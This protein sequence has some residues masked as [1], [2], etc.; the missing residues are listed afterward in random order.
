MY[1]NRKC[2]RIIH[3]CNT[4]TRTVRVIY[5]ALYITYTSTLCLLWGPP[6]VKL[7]GVKGSWNERQIGMLLSYFVLIKLNVIKCLFSYDNAII[8]IY[9]MQVKFINQSKIF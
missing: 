6:R 9:K 8:I 4:Y 7:E 2:I 5:I 3:T 1:S